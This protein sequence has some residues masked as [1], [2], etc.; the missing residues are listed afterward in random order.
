[1]LLFPSEIEQ[2]K[3]LIRQ[4]CRKKRHELFLHGKLDRIS[5]LITENILK[6]NIFKNSKHIMLFYPLKEEINLLELLKCDDK[7]FYFPKCDGKN[8][9]VCPN[10]G[11]FEKNQYLIPEPVSPPIKD[12]SILDIIFTP[13]LCA[14][15]SKFR[16]GYGG[17]FYD[18]FFTLNSLRALKII[19]INEEFI[20]KS[21]P[22]DKYD[23]ACDGIITQYHEIGINT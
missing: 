12:L 11:N 7:F 5:K 16:L 13:A 8:L 4:Y 6:S 9:L 10:T 22:Y 15:E 14:D 21:L 19:P 3:K 2:N 17:G 23:V 18:R 1:M 20:C